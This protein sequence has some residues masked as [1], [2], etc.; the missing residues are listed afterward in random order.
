MYMDDLRGLSPWRFVLLVRFVGFLGGEKA[1]SVAARSRPEAVDEA[2]KPERR[3]SL[4]QRTIV[5]RW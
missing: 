2:A 5:V 3:S 1:V 4:T